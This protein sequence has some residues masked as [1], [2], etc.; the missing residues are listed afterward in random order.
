MV[1]SRTGRMRETDWLWARGARESPG[2]VRIRGSGEL[3]LQGGGSGRVQ[4]S[5]NATRS[6]WEEAS[7]P[8]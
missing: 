6:R 5:G 1:K 4:R 2:G 3:L 8:E 7:I